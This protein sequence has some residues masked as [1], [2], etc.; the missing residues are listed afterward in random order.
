MLTR[1]VCDTL[2][3]MGCYGA[4]EIAEAFRTVRRNTIVIAQ[5]IGEEHYG[6]R[7]APDTRT[8]AQ[9]LVHIAVIPRVTLQI[10]ATERRT[11]LEGF[12]YPAWV[13]KLIAEE[14]APGSKEQIIAK[15]TEE[16]ERFA[17]WVETLSD[18]FLAERVTYPAGFHP[19]S[20]V[21]IEMLMGVKEHE[22]HHRAQLMLMERMLGIVPHLT[23]HMQARMADRQ[24]GRAATS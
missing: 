12:D 16:G 13:G 22:M 17:S 8:V 24:S 3:F 21:R 20:K 19:P 15:L 1:A 18:D 5:D 9:T 14:Q 10:H 2:Y 6:F 4:K 11:N 23:R 7:A